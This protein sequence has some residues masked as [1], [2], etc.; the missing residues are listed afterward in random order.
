LTGNDKR[1]LLLSLPTL[2][3][4]CPLIA[5]EC[6]LPAVASVVLDLHVVGTR[7]LRVVRHRS[8]TRSLHCTRRPAALL[9]RGTR[10][11]IRLAI[12]VESVLLG[13]PIFLSGDSALKKSYSPWGEPRDQACSVTLKR[14]TTT[15]EFIRP[16]A[17]KPPTNSKPKTPRLPN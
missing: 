13:G 3:T 1:S 11:A 10:K 17:T 5:I 2:L 4:L 15:S 9:I 14:S 6:S 12:Q 7:L 16:W 8:S